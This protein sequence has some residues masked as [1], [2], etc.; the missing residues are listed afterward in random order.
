MKSLLVALTLLLALTAPLTAGPQDQLFDHTHA[1][2]TA[3]LQQHVVGDRFDYRALS[4]NRGSLNRYVNQLH[5]VR[6]T[7]L[8]GWTRDQRYAFWINAYNAHV[9]Q[10]IVDNYPLDS[11]KDLGSFFSPIWKKRFIEMQSL[12]PSGKQQKL[13]LNDIEHEI[14]RPRFKDA[15]VHAAVNCAS[16]GCPPLRNEA[17]V[18]ERLDE[19]LDEQ[20][21]T[22]LADARRNRY[23][24]KD[25]TLRVSEIFDWFEDDFERDAG[26]VAKWIARY[27]P[28]QEATWIRSAK[29]V[30]I[31]HLDYSW[32]LN[33]AR[34]R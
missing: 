26:S 1:D 22:W 28:E 33:E 27:A 23:E 21:R 10:L 30:R 32:K 18:A 34:R 9:V 20:V 2:W 17:F 7:Q 4:K 11:I 29:K 19:Q 31:K 3:I 24:A 15:R 12:S 13:S 5:R 14:L 16:I 6:P 25:K 8:K